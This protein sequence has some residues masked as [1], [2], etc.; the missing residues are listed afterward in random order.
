MKWLLILFL[1]VMIVPALAQNTPINHTDYK[2]L[3]NSVRL[4]QTDYQKLQTS[5]NGLQIEQ[6]NLNISINGLH[7][8]H[9]SSDTMATRY[10]IASLVAGGIVATIFFIVH[11]MQSENIAKLVA[12][13]EEIIGDQD[14]IRKKRIRM[15]IEG[16]SVGL[17]GL[18]RHVES[19]KQLMLDRYSGNIKSTILHPMEHEKGFA[20]F[21][22]NNLIKYHCENAKDVLD[23]ELYRDILRVVSNIPRIYESIS[24]EY[25][26]KECD[27]ILKEIERIEN[28]S[29]FKEYAVIF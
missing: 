6:Q 2:N 13:V 14:T 25:D 28:L 15:A 16:A 22:I 18:K 17:N 10:F 4:L 27:K 3:E 11:S 19:Q 29:I 9:T 20:E 12:E 7:T 1:G 26:I 5:I 24:Q 23:P 21:V 8:E